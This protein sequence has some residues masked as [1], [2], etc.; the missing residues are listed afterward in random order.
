M[1]QVQFRVL[2][3]SDETCEEFFSELNVGRMLHS[4]ILSRALS[5]SHSPSHTVNGK[6]R[7]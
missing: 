5:Q 6:E 7:N 4:L 1:L 3:E 2:S